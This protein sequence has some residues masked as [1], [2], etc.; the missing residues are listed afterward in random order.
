M[1]TVALPA[2]LP[3]APIIAPSTKPEKA[4][5]CLAQRVLRV[6]ETGSLDDA[7]TS[8]LRG[9]QA[10][11]KLDPTGYLDEKTAKLIDR[12]RWTVTS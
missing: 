12:L 2:W 4:A 11:F 3:R 8:A 5:V 10:L 9:L 7:T 6:P 1:A